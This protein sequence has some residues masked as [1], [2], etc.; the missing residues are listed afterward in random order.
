M[1]PNI[2]PA[3][4]LASIMGFADI[5][6]DMIPVL[7][8]PMLLGLAVDDTIH[9]INQCQLEF[10]RTGSYRA[11]IHKVFVS[12][13]TAMFLSSLVLILIFSVYLVSVAKVY[14]NM[15]FLV[16]VGILAALTA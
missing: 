13:G 2:A 5:P 10:M 1:I 12:V 8:I 6:L 14:Q 9:F 15:G 11:S 16:G 7:I 4:A 3:L